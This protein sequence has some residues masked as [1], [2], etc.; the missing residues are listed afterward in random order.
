MNAPERIWLDPFW[1]EEVTGGHFRCTRH[2]MNT[3]AGGDI[4]YVRVVAPTPAPQPSPEARPTWADRSRPV[5]ERVELA[6][7]DFSMDDAT[8]AHR[9]ELVADVAAADRLARAADAAK[10]AWGHDI[11]PRFMAPDVA[12]AVGAARL[13]A[14]DD[15]DHAINAYR[16]RMQGVTRG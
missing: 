16:A 4:E 3:G 1:T 5:A 2:R 6:M 15:I 8:E 9:R 12:A 13:E 10:R 7:L 14:A 11:E